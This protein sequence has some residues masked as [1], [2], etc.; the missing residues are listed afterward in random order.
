MIEEIYLKEGG[1]GETS[2]VSFE[3]DRESINKLRY[4][5][6]NIS[7]KSDEVNDNAHGEMVS[8]PAHYNMNSVE[9]IHEMILLYGVEETKSFC[10]LNIHKYRTR[11][12]Y[13]GGDEDT[14][15]ADFYMVEYMWLCSKPEEEIIKEVV[16][17]YNDLI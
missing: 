6:V 1:N 4:Y 11:S 2:L 13:K 12:N 17:R 7:S 10:K 16:E 9:C 8:H 5:A 3:G 14:K 15:K